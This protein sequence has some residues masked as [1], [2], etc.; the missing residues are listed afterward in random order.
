V[1]HF[2][3]ESAQSL[4]LRL[5]LFGQEHL[6]IANSLNNLANIFYVRKEYQKAESYFK[7]A[8]QI[9][10]RLLGSEHLNFSKMQF[11]IGNIYQIQG[12]YAEAKNLYLKALIITEASLGFNHPE[13]QNIRECLN[14]LLD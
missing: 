1:L 8:M 6:D 14:Y 7:N 9:Y 4:Q 2:R 5:K 13:T 11:N 3:F 10:E 12:K